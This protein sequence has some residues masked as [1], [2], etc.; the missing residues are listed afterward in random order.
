MSLQAGDA[1]REGVESLF[2]PRGAV[3]T[4]LFSLFGLLNTVAYETAL[5]RYVEW[6]AAVTDTNREE[7]EG[8]AG[9]QLGAG[10]AEASPFALDL[11]IE[12]VIGALLVVTV[13]SVAV[14]IVAIRVFA[15]D[16]PRNF[17]RDDVA[18]W[19][20]TAFLHGLL[21]SLIVGITVAL[22]LVLLVLPGLV[23]V[24]LY[25]FVLQAV[26][27]DGEGPIDA[28]S[29]SVDLVRDDFGAVLVLLLATLVIESVVTVPVTFLPLPQVA[30]E[31]AT[32]VLDA[33]ATLYGIAVATAAFEQVTRGG[34]GPVE[35]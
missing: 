29:T 21:A 17:P 4:A 18:R 19:F 23:L 30:S 34:D 15:S 32:V 11:G 1:L 33:V 26:A 9:P 13:L 3:L 14:R 16:A 35:V 25:Y 7:L 8:G 20:G 10:G 6:V 24:V 27:L 22:G 2:S 28:V 31:V 12:G 5:A